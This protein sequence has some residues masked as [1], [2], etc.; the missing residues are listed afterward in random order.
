MTVKFLSNSLTN[1]TQWQQIPGSGTVAFLAYLSA[2]IAN[3][4]GDATYVAPVLFDTLLFG[5]PS[6][7]KVTAGAGQGVF[8]APV[9]GKYLFTYT[10][11]LYNLTAAHINSQQYFLVNGTTAVYL[12]GMNGYVIQVPVASGFR[13]TGSLILNLLATHTVSCGAETES[14]TKTVGIGGGAIN[15]GCTLFSGALLA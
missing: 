9:D 3:A 2:N 4:T 6:Y 15:S 8:T 5:D 13:W 1:T 14:S 10:L 11:Y 7:I 12:N